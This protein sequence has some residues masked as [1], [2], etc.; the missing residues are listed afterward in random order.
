VIKVTV[1][2]EKYYTTGQPD[3]LHRRE[4]GLE[5]GGVRWLESEWN[6]LIAMLELAQRWEELI[7][8]FTGEGAHLWLA[9]S[10]STWPAS[11]AAAAFM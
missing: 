6:Q 5:A 11:I 4:R 1:M 2:I 8:E 7:G 10:A 9:A 3:D